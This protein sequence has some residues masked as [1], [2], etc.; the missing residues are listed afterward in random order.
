MI[1]NFSSQ[2]PVEIRKFPSLAIVS[3]VLS[4][5][6]PLFL[7]FR[8]LHFYTGEYWI[9]VTIFLSPIAS[10]IFGA[11]ALLRSFL[12]NSNNREKTLAGLSILFALFSIVYITLKITWFGVLLSLSG[13]I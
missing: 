4:L 8:L 6:F 2:P 5:I 12:S 3:F 9:L 7:L 13:H 11:V 10:L 1:S